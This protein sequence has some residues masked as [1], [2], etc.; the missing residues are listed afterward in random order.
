MAALVLGCLHAV[1]DAPEHLICLHLGIPIPDPA[2]LGGCTPAAV[3]AVPIGRQG[4]FQHFSMGVGVGGSISQEMDHFTKG[5]STHNSF[6]DNPTCF[7]SQ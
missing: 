3:R 7:A 2:H 4:L 1:V 5:P 6:T